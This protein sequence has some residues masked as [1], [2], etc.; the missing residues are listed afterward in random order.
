MCPTKEALT[1]MCK[2]VKLRG[3]HNLV[4]ENTLLWFMPDGLL[5]VAKDNNSMHIRVETDEQVNPARG[6]LRQLV[7]DKNLTNLLER[8]LK[9]LTEVRR[10][11]F[12]ERTLLSCEIQFGGDLITQNRGRSNKS[13]RVA[14]MVP[15]F[16]ENVQTSFRLAGACV[17][18][19]DSQLNFL[20]RGVE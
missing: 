13:E 6:V 20:A 9:C 3:V 16:P 1:V 14:Y 5:N 15:V 4:V 2:V 10:G 11:A 17:A 19:D 12:L 7:N 18:Q 8:G